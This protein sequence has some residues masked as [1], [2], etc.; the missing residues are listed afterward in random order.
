VVGVC[1]NGCG[2]GGGVFDRS[3]ATLAASDSNTAIL[4]LTKA[5]INGNRLAF[6]HADRM[7]FVE[8]VVAQWNRV[9]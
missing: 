8:N 7:V 1:W 3:G 5:G 9:H 6:P 4:L 2:F